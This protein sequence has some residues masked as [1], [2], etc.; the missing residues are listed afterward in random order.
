M[1]IPSHLTSPS[2]QLG[3]S[4]GILMYGSYGLAHDAFANGV[5][6]ALCTFVG[7][8]IPYYSKL[9]NKLEE[10]INLRTALVS[11]GRLGRFIPQLVFNVG[12]FIA[13]V[14]GGVFPP[15]NLSDL[16]GV[17][18]IALLT[19]CASQGMQYVALALA[20]RELG[21]RN[22]NVLIALS[23][24]IVVTSLA[25]LG[26]PWLKVAFTVFG[27]AFGIALFTVGLLSDL[28][29]RLP[30]RGGVGVF[31][32]TFNPIHRT[33][34]ALIR[35]AIESRGLEKVYLHSTIIPKLH[36]QALERGEIQIGHYEHGMRVYE[37]TRRAD[38]HL[39]YFPTGSRF[40]EYETRE[41]MMRVAVEEA[42][43]QGK[44]EVLS[45][46]NAYAEGGF[47]A[48]LKHIKGLAQGKPIHG[49]H[50][51]DLGGMWVRGIYD[52]SGWL[53]P[54][55][56]VRRDKV[57]ATA[58]RNGAKGQTTQTVQH[59]IESLRDITSLKSH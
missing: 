10:V 39:N 9:S 2:V 1:K 57:S 51:S 58:I 32:G 22:R 27:M 30:K 24:N 35:D 15:G 43:L 26:L 56:V 31:F 48:V 6:I 3:I 54:Y 16:G 34:L 47:Y 14:E 45:L 19:T 37:K 52:E 29:G 4:I 42:G 13:L 40:Y 59:M 53:Y 36:A 49:I 12:V 11:L 17:L 8:F 28:R 38:V 50:G 21:D 25:T 18:G 23:T 46:P 7:L 44:V 5:L 41:A 55:P 20:N 33:H